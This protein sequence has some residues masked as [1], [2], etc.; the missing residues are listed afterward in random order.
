MAQKQL[1]KNSPYDLPP[2]LYDV[3]GYFI[4]RLAYQEKL[5][6]IIKFFSK[7][8]G[9]IHLEVAVGSGTFLKMMLA[10][11]TL[12]KNKL[13]DYIEAFDLSIE[14]L[15]GAKSKFK[16][17][18]NIAFTLANVEKIPYPSD[19]FDTINVANSLHCFSD[20]HK[21]MQELYRVLKPEGTLAG[22]VLLFPQ[23]NGMKSNLSNR[24][25]RWG[26]KKQILATP[27]HVEDFKKII[28]EAGFK[29]LEEKIQSAMYSFIAKK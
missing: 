28:G 11:K 20:I 5:L 22:N 8:M 29:I 23:G 18:K 17:K 24:I 10:Y 13:P 4:L 26:I 2:W 6:N 9:K 27:Y 15:Q 25:N 21:A 1:E 12:K 3:R 7:N 16:N 14:M 19:H